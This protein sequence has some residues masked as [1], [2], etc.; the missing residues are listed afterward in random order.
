MCANH[1]LQKN[2]ILLIIIVLY[3]ATRALI[4]RELRW[5]IQRSASAMRACSVCFTMLYTIPKLCMLHM[6]LCCQCMILDRVQL[7]QHC[8]QQIMSSNNARDID[9]L[10]YCALAACTLH[11]VPVALM[12]GTQ[13]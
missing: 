13:S 11:G 10:H 12:K 3:I 1:T 9:C 8:V 6:V 2:I 7:K 4:Q 5:V